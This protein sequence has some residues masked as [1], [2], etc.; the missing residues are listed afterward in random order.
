[1]AHSEA[2]QLFIEEQ[3]EE[4]LK[5]GKTPYSIGKEL[6]AMIEKMFETSIPHNTLKDRAYRMQ[7]K[8]GGNQPNHPTPQNFKEFPEKRI[9]SENVSTQEHEEISEKR[10][11]QEVR[12]ERGK[13]VKVPGPGRPGK[14]EKPPKPYSCARQMATIAISQLSRVPDDDP[15]KEREFKRVLNWINAN[16][17][18]E[19]N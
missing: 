15:Y 13:F 19:E 3:I 18:K 14:F 7:K 17:L 8:I 6:T 4:G 12:D 2:C 5:K 9:N 11:N 1:M 16:L 10:V